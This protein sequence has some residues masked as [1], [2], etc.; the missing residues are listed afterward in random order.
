[1]AF[2]NLRHR[3]LRSWLTILGIFI[4]IAAVVS[5]ISMGAG[6][7]T[8]ITGQFGALSVDTLTIQ[9]KGTGFGPPGSTVVEKLT[10]HDLELIES[11]SGVDLVVSRL[12]RVGS[13]EYNGIAGFG[14]AVNIPEEKEG[15][16]FIYSGFAFEAQ[17]GRLL[18]ENDEGKIFLGNSFLE[19]EDFEKPFRIGKTV[20]LNGEPFEIVGFLERSNTFQL[21]NAVFMTTEDM[22]DLFEV[23]D[24]HDLIVA[25]VKDK[26]EIE[27]VSSEIERKLLR[28][29]NEK[30][31]EETFTVETPL[32]SLSAVT[33]I[34][35][36]INLI[37]IGIAA[38]SL[39]VGGIGIANTMYTSVLERTNEIGIM[40]AIGAKN[41]DI[42]F[43]FLIESGFLGLVGGIVGALVGLGGALFVS[44]VA[45]QALGA[46]LFKVAISYSL[47]F[48]AVGFS[49]VVGIASGVFPALQ[50]SKLNIV[51][52]L[53]K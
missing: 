41:K 2:G 19:T 36:I 1:M 4:G 37:V 34:L 44:N 11:V 14:F 47:L 52:A 8:A 31:G 30:L 10:D 7:E 39:F 33:T 38:I 35:G 32:Q 29:R 18:R 43:I 16:E 9:N 42:L 48:G 40:K 5:L 28:D 15:R 49:F 24:E 12:I 45:N 20:L 23:G 27:S 46:D 3:G 51:E 53:R 13:L 50:A 25:Q 26:D 6:L 22:E 17:E 21:N